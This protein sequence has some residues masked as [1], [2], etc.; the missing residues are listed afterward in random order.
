M[1]ELFQKIGIDWK[2]ILAQ[3]LNFLILVFLLKKFLYKPIL[4]EIN[5][6]REK[7]KLLKDFEKRIKEEKEAWEKEKEK[8]KEA[9][10]KE[11]EE[12]LL[13]AKKLAEEF[14]RKNI[15]S[16][17]K[18]AER[19]I[20]TA[21]LQAKR[22]GEYILEKK[23]NSIKEKIF[24]KIFENFKENLPLELKMKIQNF[25]FEKI[26]QKIEKIPSDIFEKEKKLLKKQ[27]KKIKIK[28]I[29]ALPLEENQKKK[30]K[31]FLIKKFNFPQIELEF[32]IKEKLIAGLMLEIKG[33]LLEEN[34]SQK[35]KI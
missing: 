25:F 1:I 3:I 34:L 28:V 22:E 20:K 29:S 2:M 12:I 35:I 11:A 23:E 15:I 32:S 9:L 18:E 13:E 10:K 14:K 8:E 16:A 30:L 31:E 19:I 7:E 6:E 5:E 33:Y 21:K 17:Q 24:E 27:K 26:F 4:K